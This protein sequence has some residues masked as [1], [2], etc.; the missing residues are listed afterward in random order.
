M[1][2]GH[3]TGV[4]REREDETHTKKGRRSLG[5]KKKRGQCTPRKKKR[6][7]RMR[8]EKDGLKL[9]ALVSGTQEGY[10][11]LKIG[12]ARPFRPSALLSLLSGGEKKK[13]AS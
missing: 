2:L 6:L 9:H 12:T 8:E 5:Q 7:G 3:P 10:G 1:Q 4:A 13:R 11:R